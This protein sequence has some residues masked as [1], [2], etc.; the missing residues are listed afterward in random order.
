M[1]PMQI[2]ICFLFS[3]AQIAQAAG[4]GRF[5]FYKGVVPHCFLTRFN[6]RFM[7]AGELFQVVPPTDSWIKAQ[8]TLQFHRKWEEQFLSTKLKIFKKM[9]LFMKSKPATSLC[10][11]PHLLP[12]S[13]I[14]SQKPPGLLLPGTPPRIFTSASALTH[15]AC[16]VGQAAAAQ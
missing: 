11:P 4:P 10:H 14:R 6:W 1:Q 8:K 5:A 12:A 2:P 3:S 9:A 13:Q 16:T 15:G 7:A